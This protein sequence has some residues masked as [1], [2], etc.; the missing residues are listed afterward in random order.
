MNSKFNEEIN[1]R[2]KNVMNHI[3]YPIKNMELI[4]ANTLAV[5]TVI[6]QSIFELNES[7]K[8]LVEEIKREKKNDT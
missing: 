5:V 2:T 1:A 7:V 4:L 8:V 6:G 3:T